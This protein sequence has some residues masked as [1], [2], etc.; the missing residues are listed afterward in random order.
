MNKEHRGSNT[1]NVKKSLG[2]NFLVLIK[3]VDVL[4]YPSHF[5]NYRSISA[6]SVPSELVEED[7]FLK[8][9]S[10]NFFTQNIVKDVRGPNF[11]EG[12]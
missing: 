11:K 8:T 5:Q 12:N 9:H 4:I 6:H 3:S 7:I 1:P 10:I 2:Q